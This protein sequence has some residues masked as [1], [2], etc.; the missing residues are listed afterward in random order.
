[1]EAKIAEA[2]ETIPTQAELPDIEV[3]YNLNTYQI[4]LEHFLK[5]FLY[6]EK[7]NN[8]ENQPTRKK[9]KIR[10]VKT[11][12]IENAE[13]FENSNIEIESPAVRNLFIEMAGD[14]I[15]NNFENSDNKFDDIDLTGPS[16]EK[17]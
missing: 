16:N 10:I 7:K 2:K 8:I 9:I 17:P 12:N 3:F 5:S 15:L 14:Y 13:Q 11:P 6:V 4:E 1:M